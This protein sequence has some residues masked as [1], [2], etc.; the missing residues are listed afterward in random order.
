MHYNADNSCL[1][2]DGNKI[3]KFKEDNKNVN[4]PTQLR[5]GS[6][7]NG[8]SATESGEISWKEKYDL[9]VN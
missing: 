9:L 8:C 2:V 3:F 4:F 6:I 5:F 1:F 7:S